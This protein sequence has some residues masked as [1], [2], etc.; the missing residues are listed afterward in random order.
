MSELDVELLERRFAQVRVRSKKPKHRMRYRG[1]KRIATEKVFCY[2]DRISGMHARQARCWGSTA[3]G[4]DL[5][6]F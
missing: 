1:R 3:F 5:I 6:V 4:W 2:S